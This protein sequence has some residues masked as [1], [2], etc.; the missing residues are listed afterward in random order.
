MGHNNEA[1]LGIE[2]CFGDRGENKLGFKVLI[3]FWQL[4]LCP[5]QAG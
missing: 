5:Q 4:K 1:T 3:D 2:W